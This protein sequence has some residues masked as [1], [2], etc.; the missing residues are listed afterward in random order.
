MR[1]LTCSRGRFSIRKTAQ[2]TRSASTRYGRLSS[3][4]RSALDAEEGGVPQGH[5][6]LQKKKPAHGLGFLGGSTV[7]LPN[8]LDTRQDSEG[9]AAQEALAVVASGS[10]LHGVSNLAFWIS[11]MR[12]VSWIH[13]RSSNCNF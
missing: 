11:R 8:S 2:F 13:A 4:V 7:A 6:S 10:G 5:V 1:S 9:I 3:L 12:I